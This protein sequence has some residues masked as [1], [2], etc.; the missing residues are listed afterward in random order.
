MYFISHISYKVS[1]NYNILMSTNTY[2]AC[3]TRLIFDCK[4]RHLSL[5]QLTHPL[6]GSDDFCQVNFIIYFRVYILL[7][8][9]FIRF[10][11][12]G[13]VCLRG[14]VELIIFFLTHSVTLFLSSTVVNTPVDHSGI[15]SFLS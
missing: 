8:I 3:E 9:L 14:L 5:F 4:F 2:T 7:I 12:A 11:R 10:I 1:L 13:S 6:Q 15:L